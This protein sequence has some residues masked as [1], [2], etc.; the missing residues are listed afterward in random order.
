MHVEWEGIEQA[1]VQEG[2][3]TSPPIREIKQRIERA[4]ER[5]SNSASEHLITWLQMPEDPSFGRMIKGDCEKRAKDLSGRL[6]GEGLGSYQPSSLMQRSG[7]PERWSAIDRALE[8]G[9]A[10]PIKGAS[11]YVCGRRSNFTRTNDIGYH[12]I[13]FLGVGTDSDKR[14]FYLGLDPDTGATDEARAKWQEL[15]PA[16]LSTI[17]ET[18]Q[19]TRIIKEMI[20]GE[21]PHVFGPLIRKYYVDTNKAFPPLKY[22]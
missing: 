5:V 8:A 19:S 20:L 9:R 13:V 6:C 22:G 21:P 10:A 7:I 1:A 2:D 12:V 17:T 15:A 3:Q 11:F 18:A 4:V 14:K 16:D